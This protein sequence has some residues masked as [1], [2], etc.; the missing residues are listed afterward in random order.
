MRRLA[1]LFYD[2]LLLVALLFSFTL[3]V[4]ALRLG[5]PVPPDSFWFPSCLLAIVMAFFC[6]FWVLGGQTVGMRAWRIRL[7]T[8]DG[9]RVGW[10]RACGRFCAALL[11]FAPAGLGFWWAMRDEHKRSWHDL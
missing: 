1:A 3:V 7:V 4:I 5:E 10:L 8:N 9:G 6:G 2:L 11:A